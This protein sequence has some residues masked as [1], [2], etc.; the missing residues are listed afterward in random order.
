LDGKDP[1]AAGWR[2]ALSPASQP[3]GRQRGKEM[4]IALL[5][6]RDESSIHSRERGITSM[7]TI[8]A[9]VI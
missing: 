6:P 3:A 4:A 8:I 7:I 1:A 5:R 2:D 9:I